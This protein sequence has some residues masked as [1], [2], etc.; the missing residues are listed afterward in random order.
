MQT[1]RGHRSQALN[2]A[3]LNK[4][5]YGVAESRRAILSSAHFK[6]NGLVAPLIVRRVLSFDIL[7]VHAFLSD[8]WRY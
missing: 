2:D 3:Y 8:I 6:G 4:F 5:H 1:K 7:V